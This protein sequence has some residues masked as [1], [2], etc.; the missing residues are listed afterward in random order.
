[1]A[2]RRRLG[3][4]SFDCGR[5][6]KLGKRKPESIQQRIGSVLPLV[7]SSSLSEWLE[8]AWGDH[9]TDE[10]ENGMQLLIKNGRIRSLG[11]RWDMRRP[12]L[13]MF[14]HVVGV[15]KDLRLALLDVQRKRILP[16]DVNVL[17]WAAA[18]SRGAWHWNERISFLTSLGRGNGQAT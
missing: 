18:T 16:P 12:H 9:E 1:V 4:D 7:K 5:L 6:G 13:A 10:T 15:A 8:L 14:G 17:S 3:E 11:A 2:G